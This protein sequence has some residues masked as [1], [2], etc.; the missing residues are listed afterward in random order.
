[1]FAAMA[2]PVLPA[3]VAEHVTG[4]VGL[5][6][7]VGARPHFHARPVAAPQ[8]AL[9]RNCCHLAPADVAALYDLPNATDGSGQTLVVAG[10][11]RWKDDHVAAFGAQGSLPALPS[12]STQVCTGRPAASGCRFNRKRSLEA[13]LDVELGHSMAPGARVVNYMAAS[14]SLADLTIAYDQIVTDGVGQ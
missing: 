8:A 3:G 12:G 5:D 14:R 6:D 10:V 2:E 7:L 1:H 11:Y 9:G 4:V 13:A